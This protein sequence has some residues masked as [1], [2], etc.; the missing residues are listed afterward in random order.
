VNIYEFEKYQLEEVG[1]KAER[2]KLGQFFT[3]PQIAIFMSKLINKPSSNNKG[4]KI[5]DAGAGAGV[6]T[7]AGVYELIS[8]GN[9][10]TIDAFLYESDPNVISQLRENMKRLKN[11]V[12]KRNIEF[13]FKIF[14]DD[15][16]LSRFDKIGE[17]FDVAIINPPYF[18]Y[19]SQTSAYR[20]MTSDL[21]KGNPNIYASFMAVVASCL[22]KN[23]Q[24]IS[25]T[26]RSFTNGLYFKGFR[27]FIIENLSLDFIHIFKSRSSVFKKASVLQENIICSFRLSEQNGKITISSSFSASDFANSEIR[28]YEKKLIINEAS[29]LNIINIPETGKDAEIL[30]I[31]TKW[32]S[33]FQENG[34]FISTGP[35]VEFRT[36]EFISKVREKNTIPLIRM[37]NVKSFKT[38]WTGKHKK[39]VN[40]LVA[41]SSQK[42][43]IENKPYVFLKRFSSKDEKRRLVAGITLPGEW[44]K[45]FLAVENHLNYVGLNSEQFGKEELYG[46]AAIFNSTF[47][48]RYFRSISG[49]TQV[50]A[51]EVRLLK[52]PSRAAIC[53]LGKKLLRGMRFDLESVDK[54]IGKL[55][56][57]EQNH[58]KI[59]KENIRR[60]SREKIRR[61]KINSN[62]V[63]IATETV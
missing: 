50:N 31:A 52:L 33:S 35:V 2:K 11:E 43:L 15:F 36:N 3:D 54:I 55:I 49:N 44:N 4:F 58:G 39:D 30:R 6:L 47:M 10:E 1:S 16:I 23:G 27:K 21:F 57:W 62:D 41:D 9:H 51:T 38:E 32:N 45:P 53:K 8:N 63:G 18:K 19:N 5:L 48:D 7:I 28:T 34:Y 29:G 60:S 61:S 26:P 22:K 56:G 40:F 42:H 20:D 13:S 17:K 24:L 37:H 25:I 59:E 12:A 46:V 14:T